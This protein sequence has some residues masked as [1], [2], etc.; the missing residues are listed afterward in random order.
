MIVDDTS[1][2]ARIHAKYCDDNTT[3]F[4]EP[5]TLESAT[6]NCYRC[7]ILFVTLLFDFRNEPINLSETQKD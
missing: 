6:M 1:H 2:S 7:L 4:Y 5:S 3:S